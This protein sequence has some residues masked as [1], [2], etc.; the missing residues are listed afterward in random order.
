MCGN[1]YT[2]V[3]KIRIPLKCDYYLREQTFDFLSI[4]P[5]KSTKLQTNAPYIII[6][7]AEEYCRKMYQQ[8]IVTL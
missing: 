5:T 6:Q 1:L 4:D 3:S 8:K 7:I 2:E